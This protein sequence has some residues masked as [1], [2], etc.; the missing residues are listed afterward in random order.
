TRSVEEVEELK[1]RLDWTAVHQRTGAPAHTSYVPS[2]LLWVAHHRPEWL[3][4]DYWMSPGEYLLFRLTGHRACGISMASGTGLY[5]H[6][7]EDWDA[8]LLALLPVHREQLSPIVDTATP[9]RGLLPEFTARF[10]ALREAAWFPAAGDGACSNVGSG[11]VTPDRVA[12]MVGTSGA[13]RVMRDCD[14]D[15]G[16]AQ[17]LPPGLWRYRWDRRRYLLGGALSNGGNLFAWL[18]DT[19]RLPGD[20]DLE[21]C[22][23]E[24]EPDAHGLTVLPFLAGERCPGWR[25]D[26]RAAIVGLSWNTRPEE[27]LRAGLE[28]VAYRFALIH[29]LLRPAATPDHWLIASGGA[30]LASPA[31]TQIVADALGQ[32]I[33]ASEEQEASAR[34]AAL[35]ALE[36]LGL[37]PDLAAVPVRT[38]RAFTP[39]PGRHARYREARLRQSRL[40]TALVEQDW[41]AAS[42]PPAPA[43][44]AP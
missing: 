41:A 27:I 1:L 34:G 5:N 26:A 24:G 19:L 33:L 10:P 7:E 15:G 42:T 13:L 30:L 43:L 25:G 4:A 28:A 12:L 20:A 32:P 29:E 36:G 6:A 21:R 38:G 22:L 14:A 11:C 9:F 16:R 35:L 37:V 8:E 31:W 40:Y 39:H 2:K 23:E 18:R 44:K 17:P 3:R